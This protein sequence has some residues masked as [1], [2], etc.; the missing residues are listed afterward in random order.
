MTIY[1]C[2][3][4]RRRQ[5]LLGHPTLNGIDSLEVLDD[6]AQP[7]ERQR[8][9]L[10][11]FVNALPANALGRNQL[12]I[13]GGERIRDVAIQSVSIG[14]GTQDHV[15][16]LEVNHPGD[17]STYQLRLTAN[18]QDPTSQLPPP[19]FDPQLALIA[20]SFKVN[21]PSDFDCRTDDSCPAPVRSAPPIDYL[22]KDYASFRQLLLDR[23]ATLAPDW[24]T[25]NPADLGVALVELLAYVGDH[26]S[27]Q[28]DAVATEAY[29]G[30]ARKRVSVRRHA[31]LVDY[32]MHD[33]C[34]ARAWVQLQ[35]AA[36]TQL[37]RLAQAAAKQ[38]T[39]KLLTRAVGQPL[40]I[41]FD[42][43][44]E[45]QLQQQFRSRGVEVFELLHDATLY[46]AHNQLSFYTW[47]ARECCL[48]RGATRAT[49]AG[50]L[51]DLHPGDV[52][53]LLEALGPRTGEAEDADPAHRHAVRLTRVRLTED[54]LG[55]RFL[56]PPNDAGVPVTEIE[57]ANADALPFALTVSA[58]TDAAHGDQ[59]LEGVSVAL[60]NIVLADHGMTCSSEP[61]GRAPEPK[62]ARVAAMAHCQETAAPLVFPPFRPALRRGPLTQA[63]TTL[64]LDPITRQPRLLPFDSTAAAASALQWPMASV[65]PAITLDRG[66]WQPRRDLLA[67][68][69]FAQEFVAE[70]EADGSTRLRFGDDEHGVRPAPATELVATYRVGNGVLGN[71]GADAIAHVISHQPAILG[72]RNPLP[73]RGGMEPESI[74]QVRQSAPFAFRTQQRAVTPADYAVLAER[75]PQVQRAAATF[76]WTGSWRTVF[77]TADRRGGAPVDA[78]FEAALRTDLERFRMAGHDLEIDAP[79]FV[80]LEVE[81]TVCVAA[82]YFRSSVRQALLALFSNRVLSDGRRGVFHADQFTF[83]QPVY[84]SV[85]YHAAQSVA[86]VESLRITRLHRQGQ[87]SP[88]ALSTGVLELGRLEIAR[89]DNDPNFPER[90]VLRLNLQGGK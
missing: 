86:G 85:L 25:R 39:T 2:C 63:A 57:W 55:G 73:A 8:K 45:D 71:V 33:G 76:R 14:N 48:A 35:V 68:D 66:S 64:V 16:T 32:P 27:Y 21:C 6:P 51:P 41:A 72:V 52:L 20:F 17:F 78:D 28:Q 89:C 58:R 34:N 47:G 54:P 31:R 84:S 19:G 80:S 23:L 74:E 60:G 1:V 62:R 7:A 50:H 90:G 9:L 61:L 82:D 37:E 70:I 11:R 42:A 59:Q 5:V 30:T 38:Y 65:L 49:L 75:D 56:Q 40:R 29:L 15:L 88:L 67:S 3:D 77:V 18:A 12:R 69:R 26:L 46:P 10:V 53:I 81:M 79:R 87:Y 36:K 4:E 44:T 24:R 13:E 43:F 83:G 22:A